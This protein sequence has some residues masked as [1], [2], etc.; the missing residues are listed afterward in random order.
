MSNYYTMAKNPL[1]GEFEK[2]EMLD[3][4]FGLHRYGVE[5]ENG[6]TNVYRAEEVE[7]K[8][9]VPEI[10]HSPNT[11]PLVSQ[12]GRG[13]VRSKSNGLI[14]LSVMQD[15]LGESLYPGVVV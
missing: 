12:D 2:V 13:G 6:D 7:I 11:H 4:Y 8:P 14:C 15:L 9:L 3:N 1:T 10:L 5:F